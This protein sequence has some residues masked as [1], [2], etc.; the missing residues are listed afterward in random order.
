MALILLA[1]PLGAIP[2]DD[3]SRTKRIK[4]EEYTVT[5]PASR[6][7]ITEK[8]K[9]SQTIM[10]EKTDRRRRT[11]VWIYIGPHDVSNMYATVHSEKWLGDDIRRREHA[12][13]IA[14][15]VMTGM[16]ELE[17]VEKFEVDVATKHG[18]VMR[19]EQVL[20][21][22]ISD[23]YLFVYFPPDFDERGVAYK[24]LYTSI[25][26]PSDTGDPDLTVFNFVIENFHAVTGG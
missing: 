25:R 23:G 16:Y 22:H 4:M 24:F 8:D 7:W 20:P 26:D 5:A 19:Y 9:R 11:G 3:L 6:G 10:I 17:N 2:A 18:Y 1:I 21:T 15:G 12:N 14:M 13:M